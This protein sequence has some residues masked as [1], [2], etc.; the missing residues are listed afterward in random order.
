M[1]E[2]LS[3]REYWFGRE[4]VT[5]ETLSRR[6][7]MWFSEDGPEERDRRDAEIT[8]RFAE[9]FERAAS[10]ALDAWADGPRRRLS[11]IIL[12]DQFPRQMF[13]GSARAFACDDKALGLTLS[14]MQSAADAALEARER[15]FFYM[16][17][18]H[19]ERLEVQEE[20]VLAYRR[21][22]DEAP[23]ALREHFES[24]L[25]FAQLHRDIIAQFGRFPHRNRVLGRTSTPAE[26]AWLAADGETFDQ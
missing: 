20:S 19:A 16:P 26:E 8:A 14:G 1:D 7:R 11:L 17:L 13:R 9:L 3:V 2:A 25:H 24:A 23:Q 18:Q 15:M 22:L 6:M 4:R 21:L 12:L 10:G 5:C